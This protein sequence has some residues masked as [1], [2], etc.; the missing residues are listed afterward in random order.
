MFLHFAGQR[1]RTGCAQ[2]G[3]LQHAC[4]PESAVAHRLF[5][6]RVLGLFNW[7]GRMFLSI[8]VR[9]GPVDE[10][11]GKGSAFEVSMC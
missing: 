2:Q 3:A 10:L 4:A 5:A 8:E 11:V 7:S 9:P 6:E 1:P